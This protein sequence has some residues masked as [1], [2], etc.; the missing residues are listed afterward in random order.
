MNTRTL[1]VAV[2]LMVPSVLLATDVEM[3]IDVAGA[4]RTV[5][6]HLDEKVAPK[7]CENF[8][9][10]C[11]EGFYDGIQ[12]HRVI[13]NYIVQTGDPLSRDPDQRQKWGTGGPDYTIPAELGGKHV[14]GALAASRL[15]DKRNPEKASSGS[16]FYV[17]LRDIAPLDGQYTVFGRVIEGLEAFDEISGA[18][19]D[20]ENIPTEAIVIKSTKVMESKPSTETEIPNLT[21]APMEPGDPTKSAVAAATQPEKPAMAKLEPKSEPE[22]EKADIPKTESKVAA[23]TEAPAPMAVATQPAPVA[24]PVTLSLND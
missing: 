21:A 18:P 24:A 12:V 17:A 14:R 23:V 20:Q 1:A 16:Q 15:P 4:E 3:K 9:K 19:A 11:R 7:T 2:T 13:P 8:A 6:I 22:P 5:V 10:L